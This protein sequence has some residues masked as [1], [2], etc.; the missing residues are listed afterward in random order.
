MGRADGGRGQVSERE[1][2]AGD[3]VDRVRRRPVEAQRARPFSRGR[4]PSR[5]RRARPARAASPPPRHAPRRSARRRG[6]AS[7][8]RRAGDGRGTP[9]G[10]AGDGCT[11]ASASR[12]GPGQGRGCAPSGPRPGRRPPPSARAH[13]GPGRSPPGRYASGRCGACRRA[14]PT[15]SVRRRSTAMWMSSSSASN[16]NSPRSSSPASWSRPPSRASAS[17]AVST[18][19]SRE[20]LDVGARAGDVLRPEPPVEAD[21]RVQPPEEIVGR[22]GEAGHREIVGAGRIA[23]VQSP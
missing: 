1:V 15:S 6:G 11:R 9:A 19:A 4:A 8:S 18:S 10:P 12:H 20:R 2:A 3:R 23:Q 16:G 13:R 14:S 22:V 21:R 7:R 17:S 5:C